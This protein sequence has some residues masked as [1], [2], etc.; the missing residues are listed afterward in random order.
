MTLCFE[1]FNNNEEIDN[2]MD[3]L[4]DDESDEYKNYSPDDSGEGIMER[5]SSNSLG[6]KR[7]RKEMK[8]KT[9]NEMKKELTHS[10]K[11]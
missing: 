7:T 8:R 6:E 1:Y 9:R 2:K 11:R 5:S 3:K 4:A 10:N